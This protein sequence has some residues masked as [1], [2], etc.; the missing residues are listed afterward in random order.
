MVYG[1]FDLLKKIGM[2]SD[3]L[4]IDVGV[5]LLLVFIGAFSVQ[6]FF[7]LFFFII[8]VF[9]KQLDTTN[10]NLPVSVIIAARNEEKNLIANLPKIFEIPFPCLSFC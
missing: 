3:Y 8:L 5:L 4:G 9:Y 2:L 7:F 10:H 6:L 1:N